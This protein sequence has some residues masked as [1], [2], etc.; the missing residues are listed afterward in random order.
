MVVSFLLK[1]IFWLHTNILYIN[2]YIT[3]LN[4]SRLNIY[5]AGY[6]TTLHEENM[7]ADRK[8]IISIKPLQAPVKNNSYT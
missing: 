3:R 2:E 7:A 6:L 1:Y 5:L 8:R 4:H